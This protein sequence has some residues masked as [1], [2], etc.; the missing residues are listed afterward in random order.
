MGK[1]IGAFPIN[2]K[3]MEVK[4]IEDE[5]RVVLFVTGKGSDIPMPWSQVE[6]SK[7]TI[8]VIGHRV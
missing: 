8:S 3:E 2:D 5:K 1:V 7:E 6:I 4:M